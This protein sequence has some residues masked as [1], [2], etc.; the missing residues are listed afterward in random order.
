VPVGKAHSQNIGKPFISNFL[1]NGKPIALTDRY[2]LHMEML[3]EVE[4]E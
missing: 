1:V 4:K 3:L 2:I